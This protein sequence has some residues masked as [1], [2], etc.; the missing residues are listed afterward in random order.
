MGDSMSTNGGGPNVC[1]KPRSGIGFNVHGDYKIDCDEEQWDQIVKADNSARFFR[2]KAWSLYDDRK[3]VFGKDMATGDGSR[4]TSNIPNAF[5]SGLL[6]GNADG[7][8]HLNISYA[9]LFG[10]EAGQ[11]LRHPI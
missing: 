8:N 7:G 3:I 9:D 5:T 2:N 4:D 1:G 11:A 10:Q 6:F